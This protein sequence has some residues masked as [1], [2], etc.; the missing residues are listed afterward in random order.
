MEALCSLVQN[1]EIDVNLCI[2]CQKRKAGKDHLIVPGEQ[3]WNKARESLQCRRQI[4]EVGDVINR[5][6]EVF[7]GNYC[8]T[9]NIKWHKQ[10]YGHFT[11]KVRIEQLATRLKK[12]SHEEMKPMY[13]RDQDGHVSGNNDKERNLRR[14]IQPVNWDQCIFC[15]SEKPKDRLVSIMTFSMSKQILESAYL[16]Q[17]LS[18]RL[19]GVND[20][21]AAEG[22]YHLVCLR[23]FERSNSRTKKECID[24]DLAFSWLCGELESGAD[25]GHVF[26][27]TDVWNRYVEL[28][29]ELAI[30]IPQSFISR[31]ATFKEKLENKVSTIFQF[32]QP[33]NVS[34]TERQT[35]LIPLKFQTEKVYET[36]VQTEN[37][38]LGIPNIP[39]YHPG[40]ED[41][42][43]SLVHVAL[44]IRGDMG[45]KAG[46]K[47]LSVNEDDAIG[48]I[49]ESLYM[50]LYLL[51][52][53]QRLIESD[54]LEEES[55]EKTRRMVMSV[56]QDLIYGVSKG[57]KWTPK[58]IG[59]TSTLHQA[60]RSKDLVNLFHQAGH[61]LSYKQLLK[62]DTALAKNTLESMDTT[63]GAVIPENFVPNTFIHFTADNIDILDE[64]LD[65]KNTFHATQMAAYQRSNN[66]NQDPLGAVEISAA[67][68]LK[69]PEI[70]QNVASV[71][72]CEGKTKPVFRKPV[73]MDLFE[74]N[75]EQ[76]EVQRISEATDHAFF[77]HRQ[78]R[79]LKPG[80]TS[81][82]QNYSTTDPTETSIGHMPI[83]LAPAHEFDTLNTVIRRCMYVSEHFGQ[84]Y[85]VITVDQ[86]LYCKLMELKW[87][88][89]E[90][91][92]KLIVR[93]GGLHISM[94]FLK[95]I[96]KHMSESGLYETWIE[97]GLLGEGAAELV[98]SGKAYSKAMRA[99]KIT[100]QALWRILMPMVMSFL[101]ENN[102]ELHSLI[103]SVM[104]DDNQIAA[105][106]SILQ[107]EQYCKALA[108]FVA[109]E[110][111]NANF[112][113]WWQYIEMFSIL[114][115]FT[116]AQREGIWE[117]HLASFMKM[118]PLFMRYDH[119]NYA[120]WG[121]VYLTEMKQLPDEVKEH[122]VKGD[123]VVKC[124][125]NKFNQVD[126]DHAQE[127]LNGT[128]KRAGGIVGITR[129][130]SA[131]M[132]WSLSFNLRSHMAN[133]THEM[134][135]MLP[136]KSIAKETTPSR[137]KRDGEDE[138]AMFD[139]LQRFKVFSSDGPKDTLQNIATKDLAS[140]E[141]Q[142]SLLNASKLGQEEVTKFVRDRIVTP[143]ANEEPPVGF[144]D[145][146]KK[147]NA[148][149]FESLYEIPKKSNEKE[150]KT[151]VKVDRN[152]LV[153]LVTAYQ[154]GR[155]V[156]LPTILSHELFPVPL[157][158]AE[159]NGSLRTGNKS[160]LIEKLAEGLDCP[161]TIDLSG[162]S[163]CMVIDGQALVVSLGK[164][165]DSVTFGDMSDAFLRAVLQIGKFCQRIDV[166]FDRYW[167]YS[168]KE[169]T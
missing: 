61:C 104:K 87:M 94:S 45:T 147:Q 39:K 160:I 59:L 110:S 3:G 30:G 28:A 79:A 164:P 81:F 101:Q 157:S 60:T 43:L 131:L 166:V 113:F 66:R 11:E 159:M 52:G 68:T 97:S 26:Q 76:S 161:P 108:E 16:H 14:S 69:V 122:F 4:G 120:R 121:I 139:I 63:S 140:E 53:G 167:E 75:K 56:A 78:E 142:C 141:I 92:Q 37:D 49:P 103:S 44:K 54:G 84:A 143:L 99:H 34:T 13:S 146:I 112:K 50:F 91:N 155:Q 98:F 20:L 35:L 10:C 70:L 51:Y 145:P 114:L 132:R 105:L 32:F 9:R 137:S 17:K 46:H 1:A 90:F 6:D 115:S 123:F 125:P 29:D 96:G 85:T 48:C 100:V 95:V 33:L 21:I 154:S 109:V 41:E 169:S 130:V 19:A 149:T 119:F 2:F 7:S 65:G 153:R 133:K 134:Y 12:Q 80:W 88:I 71:S 152:V 31:R 148:P 144:Y 5:L 106:V 82:N 116:R 25:Q 40:E 58:H 102:S 162:K 138:Q 38:S 107:E 22:K 163:S 118:I 15:Q 89:P 23:A 156:D 74:S 168:I 24:T 151:M 57:K 83:I 36:T 128:G 62:I 158:L 135:G 111:Q 93:L 73:S 129:S 8:T 126:P 136:D 150:K 47:G 117:L 72:I 77:V 18:V 42:F 67:E 124:S 86:A 127:W 55:E 27:L 64:S 165:K